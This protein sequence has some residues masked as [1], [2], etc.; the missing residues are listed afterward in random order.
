MINYNLSVFAAK[1]NCACNAKFGSCWHLAPTTFYCF[2]QICEKLLLFP[3]F[4]SYLMK[5]YTFKG[6]ND[7]PERVTSFCT[8]IF[9]C[10]CS[11]GSS[12]RVRG[13]GPRNMKSMRL[14][15]AAIFF[16]TYFHRT[17]GAMAPSPPAPPWIRYWCVDDVNWNVIFLSWFLISAVTFS[18]KSFKFYFVV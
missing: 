14:P 7:L 1:R 13:G 5:I 15:L 12:G 6:R 8:Q 4:I 11:S 9:F 18:R 17:R 16:M 2:Q 10:M 3:V